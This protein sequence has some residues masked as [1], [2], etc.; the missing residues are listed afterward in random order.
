M[1]WVLFRLKDLRGAL[2][3]LQKAWA[4]SP[5]TEIGAHLGEV[6]WVAGRRSEAL[7]IWRIARGREPDNKTLAET[8]QRLGAQL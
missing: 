8:L 4:M 3:W 1:G 5:D 7:E 2:E 6:L